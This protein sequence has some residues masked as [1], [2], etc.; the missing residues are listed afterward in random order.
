MLF[1]NS[2]TGTYIKDV[3]KSFAADRL[4]AKLVN[5]RFHDLRHTFGTRL[6]ESGGDPFTIMELMGH[7]D[8]RMT[9]RYTHATD[10]SKHSAVAK[11]A[12]YERSEKECRKHQRV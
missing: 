10:S 6:A 11:L 1:P 9:A 8:L 2:K 12:D 3:K 4:E 5:F 7:S